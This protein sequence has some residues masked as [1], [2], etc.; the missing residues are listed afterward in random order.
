MVLQKYEINIMFG[1]VFIK[2]GLFFQIII[3]Y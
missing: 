1:L 3:V 2:F